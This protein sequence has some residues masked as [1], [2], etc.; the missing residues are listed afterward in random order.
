SGALGV[1]LSLM[2][3]SLIWR[4][5]LSPNLATYRVGVTVTACQGALQSALAGFSCQVHLFH[6]DQYIIVMYGP[7]VWTSEIVSDVL[8]FFFVM[9]AFGIWELIPASCILQYLALSKSVIDRTRIVICESTAKIAIVF[10][11]PFFT[12]FHASPECRELL[13]ATV[14]EVH[15]LTENDTVRVYGGTLFAQ[16]EEDRSVLLLA[17]VGVFPTYIVGYFTFFFTA[18]KSHR[19]LRA[20]GV[21]L[22]ARTI[23]LQRKFFTMIVLQKNKTAFLQAFLPLAVLSVPLGFFEVAIITGIAMDLKTLAL[24]FS[25]WLVPIVQ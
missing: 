7:V 23:G 3:I 19:T 25:L 4:K 14:V 18:R 17:G 6:Y 2:A 15:E 24:S 8:L 16:F 10:D 13:T 11:L 20:F 12:A 1:L 5:Q 21:K 9:A 22:S